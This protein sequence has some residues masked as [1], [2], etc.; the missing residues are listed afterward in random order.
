[1]YLAYDA[2]Q[3]Q[4]RPAVLIVHEWWGHN[5]Y[6]RSRARQ[7]AEAGYVAF[8]VDM[9]GD[10]ATADHPEDAKKFAMAAGGNLPQSRARFEAAKDYV[11]NLTQVDAT[12]IAAIGYCFGG[13]MVLQMARMGVDI[14]AV[15][16]FH[17]SYGTELSVAPGDIKASIL[18][19]H[20]AEDAFIPAEDITALKSEMSAAKADF[21]FISYPEAKHSFT[22]PDADIYGS[23]FELPLAY[24]PD[25]DKAS[26]QDLLTF[27][28]ARFEEGP[29]KN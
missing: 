25:A 8:A 19:C 1:G 17:G 14:T 24:S 22:N 3:T 15:A 11:S 9:Y 27:L 16:S 5:E 12:K 20:G 26:W 10:G 18:V 23:R 13:G 29:V 7:L 6:A 28:A 4:A 2:T 21:S